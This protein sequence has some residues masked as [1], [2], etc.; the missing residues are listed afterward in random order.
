MTFDRVTQDNACVRD[1]G[2]LCDCWVRLANG[3]VCSLAEPDP[4]S[5]KERARVAL[6][7]YQDAEVGGIAELV[8]ICEE[9]AR[10]NYTTP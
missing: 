6:A 8:A 5:L 3:K 7:M 10:D 9:V 1:P 4:K 2:K